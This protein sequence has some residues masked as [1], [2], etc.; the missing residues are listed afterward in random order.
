MRS[1]AW[2]GKAELGVE[3]NELKKIG[4]LDY[5]RVETSFND[6]PALAGLAVRQKAP[7]RVLKVRDRTISQ[8]TAQNA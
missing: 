6:V 3:P 4:I 8:Q 2:G 7:L 5:V 1:A